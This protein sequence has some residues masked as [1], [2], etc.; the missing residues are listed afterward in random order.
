MCKCRICKKE[1]WWRGYCKDCME[2][3]KE[4]IKIHENKLESRRKY[5]KGNKILSMD[6]FSTSKFVYYG[7]KIYHEG[8]IKSMQF[9]VIEM[10]IS[11]GMIYQAIKKEE[12]N[13]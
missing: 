11:R 13:G 1:I 2:N 5:K 7:D 10:A 8:F 9:R 12:P 3:R 6:E 4:D